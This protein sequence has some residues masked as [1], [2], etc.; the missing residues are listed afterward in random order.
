MLE[1]VREDVFDTRDSVGIDGV[2]VIC[3]RDNALF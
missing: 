2:F 1:S 3:C